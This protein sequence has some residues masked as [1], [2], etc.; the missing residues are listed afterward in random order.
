MTFQDLA[1]TLGLS[2]GG[3]RVLFCQKKWSIHTSEN[4]REFLA[5]RFSGQKT[6]RARRPQQTGAH[7]KKWR[8][9]EKDKGQRIK[10]TVFEEKIRT[11]EAKLAAEE[12]KKM[13][14]ERRTIAEKMEAQKVWEEKLKQNKA[15]IAAKE[16]KIATLMRKDTG[17]RIK[18]TEE[19]RRGQKSLRHVPETPVVENIV[20]P[21]E[22]ADKLKTTN[23]ESP[24]KFVPSAESR[25]A[26]ARARREKNKGQKINDKAENRRGQ[27][28]LPR[29]PEVP[30]VENIVEAVKKPAAVKPAKTP[31]TPEIK[32]ENAVMPK[33]EPGICRERRSAFPIISAPEIATLRTEIRAQIGK[34]EI[35]EEEVFTE[36][37]TKV[38]NENFPPTKPTAEIKPENAMMPK[39][40]TEEIKEAAKDVPPTE[41]SEALEIK[42]ETDTEPVEAEPLPEPTPEPAVAEVLPAGRQVPQPPIAPVAE[43]SQPRTEPQVQPNIA[44]PETQTAPPNPPS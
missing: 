12:R 7:L 35:K 9:V 33:I 36:I 2:A 38:E 25:K 31:E 34:I 26:A 15:V 32:P 40:E 28:S 23:Y 18:D 4:V 21:V 27:K 42:A 41:I 8:F 3:L 6:K 13:A 22:I 14:V 44:Q 1:D 39:I 11:L 16:R 17:V 20:G 5:T 30:V 10:E 29:V 37:P 24:T 19:N 43:V